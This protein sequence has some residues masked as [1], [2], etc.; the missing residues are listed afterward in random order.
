MFE[1]VLITKMSATNLHSQCKEQTSN[2]SSTVRIATK[3]EVKVKHDFPAIQ[4]VECLTEIVYLVELK[5]TFQFLPSIS[6]EMWNK[7]FSDKL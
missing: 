7:I 3:H 6:A 5:N 2:Q 1:F 4:N